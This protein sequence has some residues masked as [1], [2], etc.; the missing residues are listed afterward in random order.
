LPSSH[1]V[2]FGLAGLEQMPVDGLQIPAAWQESSAVQEIG[3]IV[4]LHVPDWQVNTPLHAFPSSHDVPV[5]FAGFEQIPVNGLQV[6]AS[7]Q[8][9]RAT[10]ALFW[11]LKQTGRPGKAG[12][13]A[14]ISVV[15]RFVS[16]QR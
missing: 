5:A 16:S 1:D 6:P 11:V 4:R 2:P 15:Q 13:T 9:S 7:W 8:A 14:H 12:S 10:Q 3:A